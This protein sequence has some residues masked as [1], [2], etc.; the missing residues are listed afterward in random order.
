MQPNGHGPTYP[1]ETTD[2]SSAGSSLDHGFARAA[3][4]QDFMTS[5][6]STLLVLAGALVF[7]NA[8]LAAPGQADRPIKVADASV[9]NSVAGDDA[10]ANCVKPRKRLWIEGEGWVVRRV[11]ICH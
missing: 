8:A 11:T 4:R 1:T 6:F 10:S 3:P 2:D 7:S 9:A 5:T